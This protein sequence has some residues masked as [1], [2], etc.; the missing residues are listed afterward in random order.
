MCPAI[1]ADFLGFKKIIPKRSRYYHDQ[2]DMDA[3]LAGDSHENLPDTF[4]I[5][6]CDF[7]LIS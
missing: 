7:L 3:L 5:F 4:V 2:T 6:I 1:C